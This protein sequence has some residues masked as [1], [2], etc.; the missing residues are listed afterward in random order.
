MGGGLLCMSMYVCVSV[1]DCKTT[2]VLGFAGQRADLQSN[3]D[4][5]E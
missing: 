4:C 2:E 3:D 5:K 1:C